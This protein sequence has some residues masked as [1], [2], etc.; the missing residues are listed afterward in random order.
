MILNNY[1][2]PPPKR[3]SFGHFFDAQIVDHFIQ[4]PSCCK[5]CILQNIIYWVLFV[6]SYIALYFDWVLRD[7]RVIQIILYIFSKFI[8]FAMRS[9]SVLLFPMYFR[10]FKKSKFSTLISFRRRKRRSSSMRRGG[11][12]YLAY[13]SKLG[14]RVSSLTK[15][16]KSLF[17]FYIASSFA[18]VLSLS[19]FTN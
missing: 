8:K 2:Q 3:D 12:Q 13:K 14:G 15:L 9:L 19:F 16:S 17:R 6:S 10:Y 11:S 18:S 1:Y 7:L 4:L 5:G